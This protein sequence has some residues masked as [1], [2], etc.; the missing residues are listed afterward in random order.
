MLTTKLFN[1]KGKLGEFYC[2]WS[3]IDRQDS[4]AAIACDRVK[5]EI[6]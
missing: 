5:A 4:A 2:A 3:F 1:I 6:D